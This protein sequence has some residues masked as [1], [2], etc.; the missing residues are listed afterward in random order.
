MNSQLYIY[1]SER[2]HYLRKS[3][4]I[5]Q[6]KMRTY[7][8]PQT[9]FYKDRAKKKHPQHNVMRKTEKLNK[10]SFNLERYSRFIYS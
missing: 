8:S 2:S 6:Y 3:A 4:H 5:L 1:G 9:R 10:G 7:I